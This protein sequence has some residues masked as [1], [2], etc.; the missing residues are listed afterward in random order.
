MHFSSISVIGASKLNTYHR[1]NHVTQWQIVPRAG[2]FFHNEKWS[3]TPRKPLTPSLSVY[4][5]LG[6][7]EECSRGNSHLEMVMQKSQQTKQT[8]KQLLG[9]LVFFPTSL[10]KLSWHLTDT[11]KYRSHKNT[12]CIFVT[13]TWT[14][15]WLAP[16]KTLSCPLPVIIFFFKGYHCSDMY[17]Q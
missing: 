10:G 5:L 2:A 9:R 16:E 4:S 11:E 1:S 15:I 17:H 12:A 3:L 6:M 14:K 7:Q 13:T 8:V